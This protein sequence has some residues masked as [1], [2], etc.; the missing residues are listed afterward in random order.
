VGEIAVKKLRNSARAALLLAGV[1]LSGCTKKA[2]DAP[3]PTPPK[4]LVNLPTTS[5]ILDYEDFTGR[6]VANQTVDIRARVTG[7]LDKINFKDGGMVEKG[8]LLFEIDPRPY[9]AELARSEATMQ[10]SESHLRRL[11][12]DYQRASNLIA[13]KAISREQFDQAAGD[14]A[15]ATGA[16]G[17]AQANLKLARL[18]LSYTKVHAE[19]NGRLSRA[20]LDPGNLVRVDETVLTSIVALDPIFAYFDIDERTSLKIRRMTESGQ[21]R[22]EGNEVPVMMGLADEN[23]FPHKGVINFV[24]NRYDPSTGTQQV[25]GVFP[26]PDRLLAPGLFVRVRLPIGEPYQALLIAEQALGTDQGQKFVYVVGKNNNA[27]YRRIEVGKL[28]RG[29]RVVLKGLA[30]GERVIVSGLQL[31]RPGA[32]VEAKMTQPIAQAE[33]TQ[34]EGVAQADILNH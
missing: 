18:N 9:E 13:S 3:A 8:D 15:E 30:A 25:R 21:V 33:S 28:Q 32:P 17:I 7:Y 26:N 27:E 19:M 31:V 6:T 24:D 5:E 22:A 34:A 1:V 20:Q 10:Q 14:R 12:R 4:V 11:E 23:G 29:Q 16:V 2:A